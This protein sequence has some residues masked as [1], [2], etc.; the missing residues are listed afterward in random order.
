[1]LVIVY[2]PAQVHAIELAAICDVLAFAN[3]QA[4]LPPR[5]DVRV[6]TDARPL[7]SASGLL[8]SA[9]TEF[10]ASEETAELL[11]VC[12]GDS[13]Q[14]AP[15]VD[16]ADWLRRQA[17]GAARYGSI[18]NGAFLLGAAALL[19]GRR[20]TTHWECSR[21]LAEA[22]PQA[23]VEPDRIFVRDGR[24]FSCAGGAAAID[25]ML[26]LIEDDHGRDFALRL[27]RQL[28]LFMKRSGAQAQVSLQLETQAAMRDPIQRAQK[29][30]RD[31]PAGDLSVTA[32]A[33][34]A[35]MSP[36]NFARVFLHETTLRPADY[37]EILRVNLA[38]RMLEESA[39]PAQQI[40]RL[41]GFSGTEAARRAFRR[42]TG[43]TMAEFRARLDGEGG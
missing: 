43:M 19:E 12:S 38:C 42:R 22:F 29:Y 20:V 25:L 1:M 15:R 39:L 7:R 13:W 41:C 9:E 3:R 8:L 30:A 23:Q 6:V 10:I 33:A 2:A 35:A 16:L 14:T 28:V 24:L 11:I 34:V 40:A 32:L 4:S 27:A 5:Y 26:A 36:R 21:H 37:V 18:G 31:N 17:G